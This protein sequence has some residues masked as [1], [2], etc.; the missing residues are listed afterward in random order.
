LTPVAGA[1]G[2]MRPSHAER[3]RVLDKLLDTLV[4]AIA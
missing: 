3:V 1:V 2:A 4:D